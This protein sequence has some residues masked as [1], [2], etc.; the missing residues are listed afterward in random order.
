MKRVKT[1]SSFGLA[2]ILFVGAVESVL[3]QTTEPILRV[4][5]GTHNACIFSIAMDPANRILVTGSEDKTARVWDIS[6]G[7]R[8]LRI[9]RSPVGEG[10]QGHIFAV[11]L[12]PDGRT[13]ACGGRTGAPKQGD[14]CVYLFDRATGALTR[15][16]GGLPGWVQHLV[17]TPDGRFLAAVMGERGGDVTWAGMSIFRLP[18]YALVAEDRDYGNYVRWVESAPSGSQLATTCFDGFVRLYDLSGLTAR[19]AA[20]PRRIAPVSKILPPGGQLP[21]GL[22]FSPDGTRLAVG[23]NLIPKVDVLEIKGNT[24]EYAY[25]PDTTGVTGGKG[26]DLKTVAWSSD[27]RF[28]YA[29]GGYRLKK[30]QYVRKWEDGGRGRH[31]DLP[32]GADLPIMQVLSL[33]AGGIAYASRDGSF[34]MINDRDEAILLSPKA[35]PIYAASEQG[36]LLS[37]DGF[38]IQFAYERRGKSPALFSVKERRLTDASSNLWAGLKAGFTFQA[39]ITEGLEVSDWNTSLSPKLKG[40]PLQLKHELA[41]SLAITPDRSGF[42]LG[43]TISLWMFDSAGK[44]LWRVRM[45]GVVWEV[46][47]NGRVATAALG[48]GTIRW[49]RVSDGQEILAF[50][51]YPDHKRWILW[52]PSGY[53]DASP[54]GEEF[55]GWHVNNGSERAA[56]FFPASRF[57]S[58]YYRPDVIDRVLE[59]L[60]EAEAIRL[61]NEE[62]GRKQVSGASL[63]EKL[64]PVVAI[65][66]PVDGTEVS[67]PSAIIRY[68]VR[69]QDPITGVLVLVDGR[70]VTAEGAGKSAKERGEFSLTIPQR[71]CEVS[72]IARNRIAAS[73]PATIRLRWKGAVTKEEFKI[74]PKLYVVAVGVSTYQDADLRLDLAA[75]DALDFGA[76]WNEQKGLLYSGV[77]VRALTDAQATKGNILDAMEWLQRQVTS[78]DVAVLF[79]AGH[80]I[81]DSTGAFYFLPMEADPEKLKRT[82]ISQFDITSTVA[83]IAGKVLVFLDACHSGNLMGKLKRRGLVVVSGAI[84]EL[85]S[86]ENGAVV[87]S[88]AT[89][90]QYALE[91]TEWGNG[92]FTKAVVE[93][94]RG[95]A[96]YTSTGRITLNMLD[97][98]VSERV[99][100][101]TKGQQTPTTVKPPNVPDFLVAV[102]R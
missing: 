101:L 95:K 12:S 81:T 41:K 20:S 90:R 66:S 22:A 77:E 1:W 2:A 74:K 65:L 100:E 82:G 47:G 33:R 23:F 35:I 5:V 39:P 76:A 92:A 46:N 50:F 98:Y 57:R 54:G 29:G 55:I 42:L 84:N 52:T 17:F 73:E 44:V 15:R 93:G 75:K 62:A 18:D 25:S 8:L 10:E 58:T 13:V 24:L 83:S 19:D 102:L 51:P 37:P 7:V 91:N 67:T 61:A 59:T 71:D 97:L 31:I 70:P 45:P 64:P 60:D 34:G 86:P 3:A 85:S 6:D 27:G 88:S 32:V 96:D 11:A 72:V 28:L 69:A 78:K 87:F 80:G 94:I 40:T 43:T 63:R 99:K 36:F 48:D 68:S 16:L 38:A 26:I 9:L 49:Y 14:A 79:F 21:W 4:E 89:G 56:D 30:A 53:Y